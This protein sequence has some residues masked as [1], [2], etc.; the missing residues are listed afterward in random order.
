[1]VT[2]KNKNTKTSTTEKPET[3]Q[4]PVTVTKPTAPHPDIAKY[5]ALAEL[6]D[7][8]IAEIDHAMMARLQPGQLGKVLGTVVSSFKGRLEVIKKS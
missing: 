3:A 2:K 7:A 6:N 1:M 4:P 5:A 8:L